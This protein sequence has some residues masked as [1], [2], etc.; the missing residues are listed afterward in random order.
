MKWRIFRSEVDPH[1]GFSDQLAAA[2]S[3]YAEAWKKFDKL[4]NRISRRRSAWMH[5]LV[6]M[7]LPVLAGGAYSIVLWKGHTAY[8]ITAF[9]GLVAWVI[10]KELSDRR[11]FAE[12]PCPRCHSV[13][14]GTKTEKESACR[15]CGLRLHQLSP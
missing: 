6:D 10:Y 12:W 13:W 15:A 14:P 7:L 8:V 2:R 4:Q 3:P 11:R 1:E 9:V 5:L